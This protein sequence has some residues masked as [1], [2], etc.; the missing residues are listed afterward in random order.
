MAKLG[1]VEVEVAVRAV[2]VG[3]EEEPVKS[4]AAELV[5][6]VA[7]VGEYVEMNQHRC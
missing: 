4:V 7:A 3:V 1:V 5:A 2:G 6:V